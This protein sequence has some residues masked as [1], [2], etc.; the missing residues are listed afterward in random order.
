MQIILECSSL[1][2]LIFQLI[3]FILVRINNIAH[4][5]LTQGDI[6]ISKSY[7]QLVK[8]YYRITCLELSEIVFYAV[9]T[10]PEIKRALRGLDEN[11][12]NKPNKQIKKQKQKQKKNSN[13]NKKIKNIQGANQQCGNI[14][15][16]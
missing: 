5:L 16:W 4:F 12:E 14:L 15:A 3:P 6:K 7:L 9:R 11:N 1:R 2:Q 10:Y 13:S 8:H